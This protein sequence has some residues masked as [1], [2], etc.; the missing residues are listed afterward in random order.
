MQSKS[1]SYQPQASKQLRPRDKVRNNHK[2]LHFKKAKATTPMKTAHNLL[3]LVSPG[4]PVFARIRGTIPIKE[5]IKE[6][7][8]C[9]GMAAAASRSFNYEPECVSDGDNVRCEYQASLSSGPNVTY[10]SQVITC[11]LDPW[12]GLDIQSYDNKDCTCNAHFCEPIESLHSTRERDCGCAICPPGSPEQMSL[13]CS[14]V[15]DDPYI[16]GPCKRIG[17]DGRCYHD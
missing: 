17:C 10:M 13:D 8:I 9:P 4:L 2:P 1:H 15:V 11:N 3:L 5:S 6:H 16:V 12:L 14:G 7:Q